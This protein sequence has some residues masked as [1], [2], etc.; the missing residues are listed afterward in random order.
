MTVK[1]IIALVIAL[2]LFVCSVVSIT[3][4]EPESAKLKI[5]D[6]SVW[7]PSI[8]WSVASK[9]IDGVIARIG[10]R[11][12]QYRNN[13]VEDTMFY[14][15]VQGAQQNNLPFGVYFYSYAYTEAEAREEA[16][17]VISK[18]KA[19]N[20]KPDLPIYIDVEAPEVQ[21]N[22]LTN[23]QRTDIVLA[24]CKTMKDNGYYAGVYSNKYWL[25]ELLYPSEFSDYT[26]WAAQYYSYCTYTGKYDMWQ[27]TDSGTINGISGAVDVSE[28]YRN[29]SPFI[30]KYGYNGY[31]GSE[32][33]VVETKDYSKRGTYKANADLTVRAGAGDSYSSLG[34]LPKGSEVYVDYAVNGW[35]VIPYSNSTGW[36]KLSSSAVRSSKYIT[37]QSGIGYYK[38]T[39]DVLNVREGPSVENTKVSELHNGDTV[40]ISGLRDGWGYFYSAGTKRWISL[41]YASFYGTVCFETGVTD[42]YIQPIRI[43]TGTSSTLPAWNITVSDKKFSGWATASGGAVKYADKASLTMGN[44]NVVLYAA[45]NQNVTGSYSFKTKPRQTTSDG[46]AVIG[47]ELLK[48]SGFMNKYIT[49]SG[50]CTYKMA[51]ATGSVVGTGSTV[52]FT[53]AGK[54]IGK[55]TVVV[56]GDCNGDGVCDGIDLADA[57]NISQGSKSKMTYTA[58]QKK[59]A[60]VNL[61]GKV[62]STD[63]NLIQKTA[64]GIA[65]LP[66]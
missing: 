29:F 41:D 61:D 22:M 47:D 30:K 12:S 44:A 27:Y 10:Y 31:T 23:R 58:A 11:G 6:I 24:F 64:F 17:W 45:F 36:I 66:V 7:N 14:S 34:T 46:M 48:E 9:E 55:I 49:L 63:I 62:D 8:N 54:E 50:G 21:S 28:C 2:V 57:L 53:S 37:T 25:T 5:I 3:A 18:L 20:L 38:I 60:D 15:H 40:F 59:A 39:T 35:G 56:S 1:R 16:N 33:P 52:S 13:L 51:I 43:K 19:Y 42:K 32:T 4:V 65:D 26:V